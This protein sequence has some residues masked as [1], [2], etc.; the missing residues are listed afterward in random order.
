[1]V[2]TLSNGLRDR[3]YNK[4]TQEQIGSITGINVSNV[5]KTYDFGILTATTGTGSGLFSSTTSYE[6]N[7]MLK[8]VAIKSNTFEATGSL[9]LTISGLNIDVWSMISGTA[10]S[11]ISSTAGYI[12]K[13]F[14][15]TNDG[16][17]LSGTRNNGVWSDVPMY[18]K[19]ILTGSGVGNGTSGL[20]VIIIYQ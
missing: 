7:G 2:Y 9:F 12:P 18:G 14:A 17:S 8:G 19:Y 11:M 4:F 10:S 13:A 20:G 5:L 3:E 1:M 16:I 6:I 15:W